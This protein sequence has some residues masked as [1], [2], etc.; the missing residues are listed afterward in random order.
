M[1]PK[2]KVMCA[3]HTL[4]HYKMPPLDEWETEDPNYERLLENGYKGCQ[5]SPEYNIDPRRA[6]DKLCALCDKGFADGDEY[7]SL[8]N[9][10][11]VCHLKCHMESDLQKNTCK[12]CGQWVIPVEIAMNPVPKQFY[13]E[14]M[15]DL[16]KRQN[17]LL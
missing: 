14:Y 2:A 11:C 13:K 8:P 10:Y 16:Q 6:L 12:A 17:E 7:V 1:N 3:V 4:H 9:C 15:K 5:F